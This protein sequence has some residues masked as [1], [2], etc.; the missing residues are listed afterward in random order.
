MYADVDECESDEDNCHEN[1]NCT[2]TVGSFTCS[3]NPG[4]TG[5]GVTCTSKPNSSISGPAIVMDIYL[6]IFITVSTSNMH[7]CLS[8]SFN[9]QMSMNV[10]WRHIHAIPM[11]TALT[12]MAASTAHV[13]KALKAM[14]SIVQVHV[15]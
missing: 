7:E 13:G 6:C 10:N 11:P 2:N 8:S 1:A 5:D 15:Y 14:G 12:Q 4:Y 3:C 9:L